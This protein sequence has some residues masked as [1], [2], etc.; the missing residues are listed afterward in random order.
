MKIFSKSCRSTGSLGS[1]K[2][3]HTLHQVVKRKNK[4]FLRSTKF[5][6]SQVENFF[7]NWGLTK[8][9]FC[10]F[11]MFLLTKRKKYETKKKHFFAQKV[12]QKVFKYGNI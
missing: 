10:A 5:P 2:L 4:N 11:E 12:L 3:Y 7:K 6:K 1:E 9:S 8:R